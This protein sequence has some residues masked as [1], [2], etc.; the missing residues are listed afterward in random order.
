MAWS[1]GVLFVPALALALGVWS[2]G[3]KLFEVLYVLWWYTGPLN[4][5]AGMDFMGAHTDGLW[6]VYLA[7]ALALLV[8]AVVGRWRQLRYA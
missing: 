1:A 3:S 4:S 7:L 6:P 5:L 2:G 8:V